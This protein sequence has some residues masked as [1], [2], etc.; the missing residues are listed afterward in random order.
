MR[1]I[2]A[3]LYRSFNP[4]VEIRSSAW[5]FNA[6]GQH[7]ELTREELIAQGSLTRHRLVN[8]MPDFL[9]RIL[10]L[11]FKEP[12]DMDSAMIDIQAIKP[13]V[14]SQTNIYGDACHQFVDICCL[15]EFWQVNLFATDK[16]GPMRKYATDA[17]YE[18]L[19]R[20]RIRIRD[21][22]TGWRQQAIETAES[23]LYG[24]YEAVLSAS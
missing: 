4:A 21:A 13:V 11:Y 12:Y 1:Y 18:L 23:V 16:Y 17:S 20:R 2:L 6:T 8:Y 7:G 9:Y 3:D 5:L 15:N 24:D 14:I 19:R 22:L 10:K